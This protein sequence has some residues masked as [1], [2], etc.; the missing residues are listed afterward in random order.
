MTKINPIFLIPFE[1]GHTYMADIREYLTPVG[2]SRR[3]VSQV[4]TFKVRRLWQL[5]GSVQHKATHLHKSP[6]IQGLPH[7]QNI[8]IPAFLRLYISFRKRNTISF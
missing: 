7:A 5:S 2:Q 3:E 6:H 4:N 1:A 8:K